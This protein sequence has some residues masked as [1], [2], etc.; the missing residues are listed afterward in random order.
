[1]TRYEDQTVL[2]DDDG[3]T[4]KNY[5]KPGDA[6]RIPYGSI[7]DFEVF[8]MGFWSGRHRLVGISIGRPRNW[9]PWDRNRSDKRKAISLDVGKRILPTIAP[10]DPQAVE[11]ILRDIVPSR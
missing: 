7:E 5:R 11:T 3:L 8:E 4:I 9:F 2:L 10:D 6:K 1:M